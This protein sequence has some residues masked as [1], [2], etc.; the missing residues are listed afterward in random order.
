MSSNNEAVAPTVNL[1]LVAHAEKIITS[2][3]TGK[4][5]KK[6]KVVI[7]ALKIIEEKTKLLAMHKSQKDW[8]DKSQGIDAYL[9]M[10]QEMSSQV[11]HDSK[12]FQFAE[13]WQRHSH[14]GFAAEDHDPM[15]NLLG[16]YITP[17]IPL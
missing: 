8:L 17:L 15:A 6:A 13:G 12:K 2:R 11:G 10:M 7:E 14:L 4:Y 9:Q 1:L 3:A 16:E 5:S